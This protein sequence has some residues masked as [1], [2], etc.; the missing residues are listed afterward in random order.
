M[1]KTDYIPA[2]DELAFIKSGPEKQK[3]VNI[4]LAYA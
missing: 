1:A 2:G 3:G 4:V